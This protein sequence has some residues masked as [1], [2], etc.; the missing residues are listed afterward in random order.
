VLHEHKP[1]H[2]TDIPFREDTGDNLDDHF[3]LHKDKPIHSMDI[4]FREDI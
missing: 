1:I 2:P 3:L 4:P